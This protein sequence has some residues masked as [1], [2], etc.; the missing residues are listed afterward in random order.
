M[1]IVINTL[2]SNREL[3]PFIPRHVFDALEAAYLDGKEVIT[4]DEVDYFAIMSSAK[5][6]GVCHD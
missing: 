5:A 2:Y 1:E 3:Y 4:I 6:A